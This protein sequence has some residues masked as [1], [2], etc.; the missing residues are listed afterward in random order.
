MHTGIA[1]FLPAGCCF[2][3]IRTT[4]ASR[5]AT[6]SLLAVLSLLTSTSLE[7]IIVI[8]SCRAIVIVVNFV[9]CLVV[10]IV[11]GDTLF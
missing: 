6:A 10:T 5:R 2:T 7:V 1:L 4:S 11:S 3:N 8:V 9:A